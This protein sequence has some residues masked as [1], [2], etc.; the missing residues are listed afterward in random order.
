MC[1]VSLVLPAQLPPPL[2]CPV[3]V[4]QSA[5]LKLACIQLDKALAAL[6]SSVAVEVVEGA[7]AVEHSHEVSHSQAVEIVVGAP[8]VDSPKAVEVVD[9]YEVGV[10]VEVKIPRMPSVECEVKMPSVECKV[11]MPSVECEVE[12]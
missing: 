11:K 9:A 8:A 5:L 7:P 6:G 12:A 10:E 3:L 2:M 1:P 4:L